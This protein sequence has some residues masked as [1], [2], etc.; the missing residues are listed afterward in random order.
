[1]QGPAVG[2]FFFDAFFTPRG[3]FALPWGQ[4]HA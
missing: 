3:S 2:H 4:L 1:L